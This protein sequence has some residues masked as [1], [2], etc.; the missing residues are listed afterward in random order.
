M[1]DKPATTYI[2]SV[3][4]KPHW[5]TVLTTKDKAKALAAAEEIGDKVRIEEITPKV[6]K[7]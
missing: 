1:T 7:R 3:F 4:E 6:K 2:F 5:R